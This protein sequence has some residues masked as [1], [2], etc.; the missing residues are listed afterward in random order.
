MTAENKRKA[1]SEKE[2]KGPGATVHIDLGLGG[3]FKGIGNLV[4]LISEMAESGE[5]VS[6]RSGEIKFGEGSELRGIYGFTVRTGIGGIPRVESFGNIHETDDGPVVT[7]VRE[8][9]IDIFE[10]AERI[11]VVVELPGVSQAEINITVEGDVLAVS[12]GG[13]R[14]YAKE[15]VLP[16][17]VAGG[18][19]TSTYNNGVLEIH[20]RKS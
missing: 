4:D 11:L 19:I 3:L 18:D 2:S 12:T 14:K 6:A 17:A 7:E 16:A 5:A 8:P 20:L 15:V 13:E 9:L 1:E 10:E